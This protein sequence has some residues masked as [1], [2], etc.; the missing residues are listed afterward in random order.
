MR[1]LGCVVLLNYLI[2]WGKCSYTGSWIVG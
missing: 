2:P 1:S